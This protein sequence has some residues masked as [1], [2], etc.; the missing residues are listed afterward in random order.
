MNRNLPLGIFSFLFFS[1][2]LKALPPAV[3][4]PGDFAVVSIATDLGPCGLHAD[5]DEISFVCFQDLTTFTNFQITDNGWETAFPGFWGNTEG[6]LKITRAGGTIPAGTVITLRATN[7][8]AGNFV[9]DI[10][11]PDNAWFIVNENLPD[12]PFNLE[13][14][15]DQVY[16]LQGGAWTHGALNMARTVAV[17]FMD[18]LPPDGRL[19]VPRTDPIFI[20]M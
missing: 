16:F 7:A 2:S 13:Q 10:I 8:G 5:D 3:L 18:F 15:G 4:N 17:S 6:T 14:G 12:G 11:S 1:I 19:M 9:Y 20:P